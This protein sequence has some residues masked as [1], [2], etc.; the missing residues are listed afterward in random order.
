VWS[1]AAAVLAGAVALLATALG[2]PGSAQS[3]AFCQDGIG[4]G[5]V[6]VPQARQDDPRAR[7]YVIDHVS[8]GAR[9]ERRIRICNGTSAP[10]E[11]QVYAGAATVEGAGFRAVEGR[12]DNELS[13]WIST[14]P[15]RLTLPAGGERLVTVR[16]AVP[17]DAGG[18]ERYAA[19]LVEAP[20]VQ[21]RSGFAVASRVGVRV[22]LSVGGPKEP[23]SDFEI[24]S[25]QAVRRADG[26]PAVTARVSN[27]GE[28]ALDLRGELSLSDG[29]GGLSAGPFAA[30]VGT[31]LLPGSSAPVEIP[32]DE[33]IRG[34]PWAATITMRSG[35][36]ERR[37][38][39]QITFPDEAGQEST[40][41][42]ALPL[43]ENP[44]VLVPI[45]GGLIALLALLLLLAFLRRRQR[46][47]DDAPPA[48][49]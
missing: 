24:D 31:T 12:V 41:V 20:A 19:I 33:A 21:Q 6:D 36:L 28:R 7:T 44:A 13:R 3:T 49:E 42:P 16:F 2:V 14:E 27:T 29:P 43:R 4:V 32:L 47:Q 22:Y 1:R 5:L 10:V 25:L 18:G 34:G 48:P 26:R 46:E 9:F 39:A 15:S 23:E 45:A 30:T 40:P 37:A 38:G 11:V 17:A 35:L 8:P